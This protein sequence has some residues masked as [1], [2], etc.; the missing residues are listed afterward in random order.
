M[1]W[2][3]QI[4]TPIVITTGDGKT[5]QPLYYNSPKSF[6][7]NIAEFNFPNIEGSLVKRGKR[8]G[9]RHTLEFFFQGTDQLADAAEFEES[10]KDQR[11][12][13][14]IHPTHGAMIMQPSS[15]TFDNTGLNTTKITAVLIET[16]TEDAPRVSVV[17]KEQVLKD[18]ETVGN[19]TDAYFASKTPDSDSVSS[20]TENT[21]AL[22][23]E[24]SLYVNDS[25]QANEYYNLYTIANAKILD[26]TSEPLAAIEAI[27]TF[28]SY[29]SLFAISVKLRLEM[30]LNQYN[31]LADG[32]TQL[33]TPNEKVVFENNTIGILSAMVST[34]VNPLD[35][36]DYGNAVDVTDV[37]DTI[38]S[39]YNSFMAN[40]D[41]IQSDNGGDTDSYVPDYNSISGISTLVDYTVSNLLQ[42]ALSAAQERIVFLEY[43]S[44]PII[45]THRFYGLDQADVNLDK[46]IRNNN[47]GLSEFRILKKGRQLKYYV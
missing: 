17:P 7:F 9:T 29:P 38:I 28:I 33:V 25:T 37:I 24:A 36:N 5:Y 22:Y 39:A 43:D 16:I 4:E 26:I 10:S 32:I 30:L 12:W 41:L 23:D 42:I 20:L 1:S 47:I 27:K 8:K 3:D 21:G 15:L 14:V 44:N 11:P 19:I 13:T 40:L 35:D 45:Q 18:V 46:F 2:V 34:V 31:S 6:D